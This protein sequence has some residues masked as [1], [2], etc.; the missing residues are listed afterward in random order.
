MEMMVVVIIVSLL[1][2]LAIPSMLKAR[3]DRHAYNNISSVAQM[4]RGARLRAIGR[5]GAVAVQMTAN[6]TADRGH[7][8]AFEA[9]TVNPM[10]DGSTPVSGAND[11]TPWSSCLNPIWTAAPGAGGNALPIDSLDF[12][13]G[14]DV[15]LNIQTIVSTHIINRSGTDLGF[16]PQTASWIC[17]TPVG[18]TYAVN[19]AVPAFDFGSTFL[20]LDVCLSRGG[21]CGGG[22]GLQR[23]VLVSPTGMARLYSK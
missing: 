10:T 2:A 16:T 7:F 23:H 18:R 8:N 5:G 6:G 22:I 17:F 12:S 20:D 9:V 1:A 15:D 4:I 19:G 3:D 21:P 14:L 13:G 11:R